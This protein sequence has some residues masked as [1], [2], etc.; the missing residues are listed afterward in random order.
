MTCRRELF[1]NLDETLRH[2]V[3]LGDNKEVDVLGKGFVVNKGCGGKVKLI[4]VVQFVPSLAHN[5]LSMGQL[6]EGGYGVNFSKHGCVIQAADT[7]KI[8]FH[9]PRNGNDLFPVEFSSDAQVN[10]VVKN[11]YIAVLWHM[12]YGHLNF[13]GLHVLAHKC[14]LVGLPEVKKLSYC[15]DCVYGKL[16]RFP[17]QFGKSWRASYKLQLVHV[18]VFGPM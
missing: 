10:L 15:E 13:E 8:L 5:L 18:Y 17:F 3:R 11:K 1:H 2:K 9:V 6:I 4:H 7:S 12:R 16:T 14:M